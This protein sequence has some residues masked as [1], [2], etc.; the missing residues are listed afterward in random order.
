MHIYFTK[1]QDYNTNISI[2]LISAARF[3]LLQNMVS[4]QGML[5]SSQ[6]VFLLPFLIRDIIRLS[7]KSI[8]NPMYRW[9]VMALSILHCLPF[10]ATPCSWA[11]SL[12]YNLASGTVHVF[13]SS[14]WESSMTLCC[15]WH[16][17]VCISMFACILYT[18]ICSNPL[19]FIVG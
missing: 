13:H 8:L 6:D 2:F 12:I 14:T 11:T 4:I 7:D 3:S 16:V 9:L 15:I 18:C 1:H 10:V 19:M 5:F 17:Y